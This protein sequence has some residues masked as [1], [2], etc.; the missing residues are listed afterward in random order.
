MRV[1]SV[2]VILALLVAACGGDAD[3]TGTTTTSIE[4]VTTEIT[5]AVSTTVASTTTLPETAAGARFVLTSVTF[6]DARMVVITNIGDETGSLEGHFLCQRPSYFALEP[7]AVPAG[8]SYA[9]ST[10]GSVFLPPPGTIAAEE[11]AL[12]GGVDPEDGEIGLYSSGGFADPGAI[13]SYVEWGSTG[14]GRSSVAVGAGIWDGFVATTSATTALEANNLAAT[15]SVDWDA[16]E[17]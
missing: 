3:D 17:N 8:Q 1:R 4:P 9:I 11:P 13:L 14:H 12:I 2:F 10:G 5:E 16:V 6:G 7:V 15:S